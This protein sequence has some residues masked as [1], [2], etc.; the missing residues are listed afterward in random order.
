MP[1]ET[2]PP[3]YLY[4]YRPIND[5]T[6]DIL[7]NGRLYFNT[8]GE[9]NDPFE[10]KPVLC[11]TYTEASWRKAIREELA[12]G[13]PEYSDAQV[14]TALQESFDN[15]YPPSP[16]DLESF[17]S[18]YRSRLKRI[19][20]FSVTEGSDSIVMW[21]HY[22]QR[23]KGLCL[24][25][26]TDRLPEGTSCLPISYSRERPTINLF[27]DRKCANL[28]AATTKT[29]DWKYEAEWR[30][31]KEARPDQRQF[32]Q[33][34]DS[35]QGFIHAVIFGALIDPDSRATVLDWIKHLKPPPNVEEA[36]LD[37]RAYRINRRPFSE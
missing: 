29:D 24:E 1:N 10:F 31:I 6:R 21:S 28:V 5:D 13:H 23:H 19:G 37:E 11:T 22:A 32:P 17:E 3:R 18:R 14:K 4:K 33:P 20:I 2:K 7:R 8:P 26:D 27:S 25:L 12:E 35:P 34:V 15:L 30:L 16:T 36:Y 9:L